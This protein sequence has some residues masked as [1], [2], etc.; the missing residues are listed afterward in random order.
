MIIALLLILSVV[1]LATRAGGTS[2]TATGEGAVTADAEAGT[3]ARSATGAASGSVAQALERSPAQRV[4]E[5]LAGHTGAVRAIAFSPD[6]HTLATVAEDYTVRLWDVTDRGRPGPR[7]QPLTG[8]T[9]TPRS[10]SFSGDGRLLATGGDDSTVRLWDVA[11]PDRP[12]AL[13]R[14]RSAGTSA[15][16]RGVALSPD[17]RLLAAAWAD[18]RATI[19]L[20]D[21]TDPAS[22]RQLGQALT[23]EVS[24]APV[25]VNRL[26]F[27]PDGRALVGGDEGGNLH[28]WDVSSPSRPGPRGGGGGGAPRRRAGG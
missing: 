16:I 5:P 13:G 8:H 4:G 22:P 20:Y 21:V 26:L 24:G 7:G 15:G 27:L 18:P 17:G 1:A 11:D 14:T 12:V 9:G 6:S 10:L 3:S 23:V 25:A 19:R 2:G 28:L